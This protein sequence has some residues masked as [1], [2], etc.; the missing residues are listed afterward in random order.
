ME[1]LWT[2][3]TLK[4]VLDTVFGK[5]RGK[6]RGSRIL[7]DPFLVSIQSRPDRPA[8]ASA[9]TVSPQEKLSG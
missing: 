9:F 3:F 1:N 2:S 4:G 6:G 7:L 8:L 5:F